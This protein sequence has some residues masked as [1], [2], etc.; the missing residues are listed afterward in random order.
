MKLAQKDLYDRASR[1]MFT[2]LRQ[3]NRLNL[4]LDVS[5]DLFDSL[6]AP[7]LTYGCEVWG[8][9]NSDMAKKLQLKF[10][11]LLL[12]LRQSTPSCMVFGETG[13]FPVCVSI[14]CRMLCFWFKLI[15]Q[16]NQCK[17]SSI[18]Y[19][20]LYRLYADGR[21]QSEYIKCIKT[22]LENIGMSGFW[23]NQQYLT[24]SFTWFKLKVK[25][26]LEDEYIQ[27]WYSTVDNNDNEMYTNY[28]MF[29]TKFGR[30]AYFSKLPKPCL[31][32]LVQ[33][34]TTNNILPVNRKRF[35]NV[36]RI[37]R[38]CQKCTLGEVGDEFHYLFNCPTLSEARKEL[39]PARYRKSVNAIKYNQIM[40]THSKPL[41]LKTVHIVKLIHMCLND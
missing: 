21:Y 17:L 8:H 19:K 27:N 28:R 18:V 13:K 15:C 29:K 5:L 39:F 10:Y 3:C 6:I 7:I 34:R 4:P 35:E 25:R 33:F 16:D 36:P 38:L 11:K 30:E 37:E 41:L 31:I 9:E 23:L 12:R 32:R 14:K 26:G 40:S 20:L 22:S 24:C 1:A 2:L